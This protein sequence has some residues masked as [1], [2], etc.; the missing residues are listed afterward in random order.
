LLLLE[1]LLGVGLGLLEVVG[2]FL[3]SSF[4]LR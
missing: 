3:S 1:L 2:L 4:F